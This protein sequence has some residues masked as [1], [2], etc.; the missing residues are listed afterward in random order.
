[1]IV[2]ISGWNGLVGTALRLS[3]QRVANVKMLQL[4]RTCS[5]FVLG[6]SRIP[7]NPEK[8][9]FDA[10]PLEGTNAVVH[11][12]GE[13]IAEKRWSSAQKERIRRSRVDGTRLLVDG[14][15]KLQSKPSVLV[16]ASAIGWYGARGDE[17]L[18]E[19]A[20]PGQ[21]FLA[22]VCREWEAEAA[23]ATEL[24]IRVVQLRIGVVLATAGGALTKMLPIF[25]LGVG[26]KLGSGRQWMSWIHVDDVA[27]AI[28][29][30]IETPSLS[31]PVN[32]TAPSP[33]A[34]LEFTKTLGRVLG[35]PTLFPAPAFDLRVAVGE[36]ADDL[37]LSGQRV[38][39]KKLLAA[40]FSFGF[41]TLEPA[42]RDLL[43]PK[44]R[45]AP[46]PS[47]PPSGAVAT[48]PT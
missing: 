36:M 29:F 48:Y 35:R 25:R 17:T 20:T 11:L 5:E 47:A 13:G 23:K 46:L 3:Y 28:R 2:S 30:A 31:G 1:M 19:S 42:L 16:C 24:G 34:N 33:V 6:I 4:D 8:G 27:A 38:V 26:G 39:P 10:Q 43:V 40:G 14:L 9:V 21:G 37:L 12:A 45:P 15:R 18:D 7:W 22:E 44:A 41:P 32:A